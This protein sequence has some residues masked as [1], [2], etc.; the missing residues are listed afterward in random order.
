[1]TAISLKGLHGEAHDALSMMRLLAVVTARYN[2]ARDELSIGQKD[3]ARMWGVTER[4]A[5]REVK[6]W[7]ATGV[8]TCSRPGV[9][10]RV[11]AYRINLR[12][13]YNATA[14]YW[15]TVG[16]DFVARMGAGQLDAAAKVVRVDFKAQQPS[17]PP[18]PTAPEWA[19][20]SAYIQSAQPQVHASWIAP[21]EFVGDDGV[22]V[23]LRGPSPF[24]ARYVETHHAKL[25]VD[26]VETCIGPL[27]R[28]IIEAP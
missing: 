27:R 9:R 3:M 13:L 18:R 26:A 21:L 7:L 1:M 11:A 2:W 10:G 15:H 22:T 25:I 12:T 23:R 4:T 19:A 20:A 5:K 17:S 8:V 16:P 14:D 6:R 28:V 24:T